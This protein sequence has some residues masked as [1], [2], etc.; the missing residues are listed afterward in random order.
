LTR[1]PNAPSS[2]RYDRLLTVHTHLLV[3]LGVGALAAAGIH[4]VLSADDERVRT[5]IRYDLESAGFPLSNVWTRVD[6]TR[7]IVM[8]G[9]A[10]GSTHAVYNLLMYLTNYTPYFSRVQQFFE[11]REPLL[12]PVEFEVG[13]DPYR[14]NATVS[15][16]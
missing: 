10:C 11:T 2:E 6:T 3:L 8:L 4:A 1:R 12:F 14:S 15:A 9:G 5:R 16:P 13:F 7:R